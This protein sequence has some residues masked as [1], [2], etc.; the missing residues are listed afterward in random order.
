MAIIGCN[1]ARR[2]EVLCVFRN[3]LASIEFYVAKLVGGLAGAPPGCNRPLRG[4]ACCWAFGGIPRERPTSIQP[5]LG[6][7]LPRA[8]QPHHGD[9]KFEPL[10]NPKPYNPKLYTPDT[11]LEHTLKPLN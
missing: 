10:R 3:R 6:M 2:G 7:Y 4:E 1:G 8:T 5:K 9:P 11:F